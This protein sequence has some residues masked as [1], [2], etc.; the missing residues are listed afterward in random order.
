MNVLSV[1]DGIGVARHALGSKCKMYFAS[2]IEPAACKVALANYPDIL[3]VG[4]IRFLTS[5]LIPEKIDILVGGS[6]CQDLSCMNSSREGLKGKKSGLFYEFVRVRDEF[7]P[8][9]FVF[10]NVSSMP[11]EARDEISAQLGV[12][13]VLLNA[14]R[15]SAQER[16][17]LWWTNIPLR[18]QPPDLGLTVQDILDASIDHSVD[19]SNF[20]PQ[21]REVERTGI[22]M[23]GIMKG[24]KWSSAGRVFSCTGKAPTLLRD[25]RNCGLCLTPNGQIRNLSVGE[26]CKLQGLPPT[27]CS[28]VSKREGY[29]S[30]GNAFNA[31]LLKWIFDSIPVQKTQE[32]GVQTDEWER[33]PKR[34]KNEM[35]YYAS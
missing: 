17:R 13:P 20:Q 34:Q 6:P 16:V 33:E 9:W 35:G 2:E 8:T 21:T 4:D 26:C 23:A 15:V 30:L 11:M 31:D 12:Q 5:T 3:H 29:A 22:K 10:E 25:I 24:V 7:K 14:A 32:V 19:L 1:F 18:G 28:A 27:Y